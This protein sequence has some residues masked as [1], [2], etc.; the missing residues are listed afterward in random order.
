MICSAVLEHHKATL[1]A[2]R[3]YFQENRNEIESAASG[4]S[5]THYKIR[6]YARGGSFPIM[7]TAPR[8]S[9]TLMKV[10]FSEI[11]RNPTSPRHIQSAL[12]LTQRFLMPMA[13]I[14]TQ[15]N[16][17]PGK[18]INNPISNCHEAE[19][20][21]V[22]TLEQI[23]TGGN[24]SLQP[25]ISVF[26]NADGE[27][28]TL[29]KRYDVSS[30]ITLRDVEIR[31]GLVPAGT[32]VGMGA[33][34]TETGQAMVDDCR[35]TTYEID[36]QVAICPTRPS[37]WVYDD[38]LDRAVFGLRFWSNELRYDPQR[39]ETVVQ[40]AMPDFVAAAHMIM[41]ECG[42]PQPTQLAS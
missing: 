36:E 34:S 8:P 22:D 14:K 12:R 18:Y 10:A 19:Y 27:P 5:L 4:L 7:F 38:P 26:H 32:I 37:P 40:Y 24:A 41:S 16:P 28:I 9:H 39:A 35:Y 29:R 11:G 2:E 6:N 31:G 1:E 17:V 3:E 20:N 15:P 42:V 30:A 33:I 23:T 21:F 13:G 25:T